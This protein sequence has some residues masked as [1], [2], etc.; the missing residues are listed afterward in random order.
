MSTQLKFVCFF[1]FSTFDFSDNQLKNDR[2]LK[3]FLSMT[4]LILHQINDLNAITLKL[5]AYVLLYTNEY[6]VYY[7]RIRY[8][9]IL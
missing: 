3:N 4:V 8:D 9:T 6:I 2:L 7:I 1:F 5:S